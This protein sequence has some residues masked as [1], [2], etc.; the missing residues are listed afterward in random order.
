MSEIQVQRFPGAVSAAQFAA[1]RT[2]QAARHAVAARG[3][4]HLALS[5]GRTPAQYFLALAELPSAEALPWT[6]TH[7]FWADERLVPPNDPASN[8]GLARRTLLE[9]VPLPLARIHRVRGELAP[10]RAL[11]G[12]V[13]DLHAVFGPGLPRFDLIHLGLGADGHTASLLPGSPALQE[14]RR[15]AALVSGQ[16][17]DPAVGR[18]TLTLP[19]LNAAR[20]VL[21]LAGPDRAALAARVAA[22]QEQKLPA[23]KVRPQGE[24]LWVLHDAA[25]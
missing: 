21:F 9:R 5:G 19:T 6:K 11:A 4:F 12:Y 13:E 2:A 25:H 24:T 23:A 16:G 7:V 14:R 3:V 20:A 8:F 15:P 10:D 17:A 1:L 22:G 18:V